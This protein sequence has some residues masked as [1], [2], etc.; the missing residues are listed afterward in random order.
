M[1]ARDRREHK[2][3]FATWLKGLKQ[4]AAAKKATTLKNKRT[5]LGL[6]EAGAQWSLKDDEEAA[7]NNAMNS[8]KMEVINQHVAK[9]KAKQEC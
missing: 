2:D 9:E 6:N 3:F 8:K 7:L 5:E 4:A 1:V